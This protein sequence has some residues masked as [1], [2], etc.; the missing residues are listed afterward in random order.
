MN[1]WTVA[2]SID[3]ADTNFFAVDIF[4]DLMVLT[5]SLGQATT[6]QEPPPDQGLPKYLEKSSVLWKHL[7]Q[8]NRVITFLYSENARCISTFISNSLDLCVILSTFAIRLFDPS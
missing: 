5:P 7:S 1:T 2:L 4:Q 3:P 8:L 6:L